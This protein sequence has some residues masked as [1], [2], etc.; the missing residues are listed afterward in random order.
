MALISPSLAAAQ[1]V[2]LT[3]REGDLSI[4]GTLQ[5]YDGEFYRIASPYGALTIDAAGV[6]CDGPACPDLTAPKATVRILTMPG[7]GGDLI[8]VLFES[9]AK[10]RGLGFRVVSPEPWS[11]ELRDPVKDQILAQVSVIGTNGE[12]LRP[13]LTAGAAE[14]AFSAI[15]D[16]TLNSRVVAMNGMVP[17]VPPSNAVPE[18]SSADLA[19]VLEGK[20]KNWS[21]I[22]GPD[23][24]LVL[25]AL[26]PDSGLQQ[27]LIARLGRG[28]QAQVLHATPAE[29][30]KA[31][32]LDPW[33]IGVTLV[34]EA[35][36]AKPILLTDRCGFPLVPDRLAIK[37]ED[38][39]LSL[40]VHILSPRRRLPLFV[41]EF[42]DFLSTPEAQ[43]AISTT[44]WVDR[45]VQIEPLTKD[46][47]RL[48]NA[49]QGAGKETTLDDL[50]RL[51]NA[52]DG[53]SRL[54]FT[55]RFKDGS[56]SLD[57]AS[58]ENLHDLARLIETGT[59]K[60]FKLT[61]A[62]FSDGSGTAKSNLELSLTRAKAVLAALQAKAPDLHPGALP[63]AL[64]FGEALPMA[65]DETDV[66]RRLNR[67]VEVWIRPDFTNTLATGN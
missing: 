46:G 10:A 4:S 43:R 42:L 38:Y 18:I 65:C 30:A 3:A 59:F 15:P 66:G 56:N 16:S 7:A 14:L 5:G 57:A 52:M 47:L 8:P 62:G 45:G 25:H 41:R 67:R 49:I 28:V 50:K 6:I 34:S 35:A 29:L 48:I 37:S 64:A 17:I 60:G 23:I 26:E 44:E 36:P 54:S 2:T 1:D 53:A 61:L 55:F 40:P 32:A 31:V 11:A 24:P 13:M 9:F 12:K 22:G 20:I 27:A 58:A 21:Q 33:A 51:V 19:K 39:P 63:E